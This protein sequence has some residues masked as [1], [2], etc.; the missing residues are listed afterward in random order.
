MT[1]KPNLDRR[2]TG[3]GRGLEQNECC[4]PVQRLK[5]LLIFVG[6][7]GATESRALSKP[8]RRALQRSQKVQQILLLWLREF[9]VR[10][11]HCVGFGIRIVMIPLAGM[12]FNRLN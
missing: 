12:V 1:T 9:S 4:P 7:C 3:F 2:A 10:I 5:P 6:F 11:D 8:P